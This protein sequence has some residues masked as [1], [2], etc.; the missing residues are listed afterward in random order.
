MM[1]QECSAECRVE[2]LAVLR[3]TELVVED[4]IVQL[5]VGIAPGECPVGRR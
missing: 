5:E 4:I 2:E 3:R 1:M